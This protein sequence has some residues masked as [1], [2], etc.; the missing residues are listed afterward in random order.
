MFC[1]FDLIINRGTCWVFSTYFYAPVIN[2]TKGFSTNHSFAQAEGC[3]SPCGAFQKVRNFPVMLPFYK[4]STTASASFAG[5]W[6][7]T[8]WPTFQVAILAASGISRFC[9]SVFASE[10]PRQTVWGWPRL[11]V[12]ALYYRW[13]LKFV[14]MHTHTHTRARALR[15]PDLVKMIRLVWK[16]GLWNF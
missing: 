16:L 13:I 2:E 6:K 10:S 12:L 5:I 7:K 15:G 4:N 1:H 8:A 3:F 9:K 11:I 14:H